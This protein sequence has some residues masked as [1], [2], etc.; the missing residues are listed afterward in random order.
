MVV[1]ILGT[2]CTK[3]RLLEEKVRQIAAQNTIDCQ[4]E[5]ITELNDIMDYGI[6]MTPGLVVDEKVMSSGKIPKDEH[7]LQWLRGDLK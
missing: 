6:M 5:K 2:G 4:I 7:I 3:C 1:K